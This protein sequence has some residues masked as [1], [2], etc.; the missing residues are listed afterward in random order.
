PDLPPSAGAAGTALQALGWAPGGAP[1]HG[2]W[3]VGVGTVK[4][5]DPFDGSVTAR[6]RLP[7]DRTLPQWDEGARN[8][9]GHTAEEVVGRPVAALLADGARMPRPTE[10]TRWDGTVTLRHRDGGTV[11]VWVLAHR[12]IT[13]DGGAGDWLAVTPLDTG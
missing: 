9:L 2:G 5:A 7:P 10:E 12:R 1:A 4:A 8:L 3:R 13:E 11:T 6:A